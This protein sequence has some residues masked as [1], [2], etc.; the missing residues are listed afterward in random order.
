MNTTKR[1]QHALLAA[2]ILLASY[3]DSLGDEK[4]PGFH[5][6][7]ERVSKGIRSYSLA[8]TDDEIAETVFDLTELHREV[9]TDPRFA[10]SS[11]LQGYRRRI[12]AKL[13]QAARDITRELKKR[14]ANS[15]LAKS[16]NPLESEYVGKVVSHQFTLVGSTL[17]GP[18]RLLDEVTQRGGFGGRGVPDFGNQLVQLIQNTISPKTWDVN[19]GP[20]TII[21]YRPLFL[22]VVRAPMEAQEDIGGALGKLRE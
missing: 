17:G 12:S 21:Y 13:G 10:Q 4:L 1:I 2:L 8:K 20:G 7:N 22:M 19:G 6:I 3:S 18:S 11:V 15:S 9:A 14:E 16:K 5:Q